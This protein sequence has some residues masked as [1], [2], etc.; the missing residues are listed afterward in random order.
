MLA[1]LSAPGAHAQ[2]PSP[3]TRSSAESSA[4]EGAI[5][6]EIDLGANRTPQYHG[7]RVFLSVADED[8]AWRVKETLAGSRA[9]IH[10]R[11]PGDGQVDLVVH[12]GHLDLVDRL[13]VDAIHAAGGR[14]L[15]GMA[16]PMGSV[17]LWPGVAARFDVHEVDRSL[18]HAATGIGASSGAPDADTQQ[19]IEMVQD[20]KRRYG[21]FFGGR[22]LPGVPVDVFLQVMTVLRGI[23][24]SKAAQE[25]RD[26]LLALWPESVQQ[27]VS[28]PCA[29]DIG[30][31]LG[32][33]SI[34]THVAWD[35]TGLTR[36]IRTAMST[37]VLPKPMRWGAWREL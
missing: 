30:R 16:R 2:P 20:L 32:G 17:G 26:L 35:F 29:V 31:L 37:G 18:T 8:A 1:T 5:P 7:W 23:S 36:R 25:N 3:S 14:L 6:H 19:G 15:T 34:D 21:L 24:S 22:D 33:V 9:P 4:G 11:W 12:A 28:A 10:M 27:G 13:S